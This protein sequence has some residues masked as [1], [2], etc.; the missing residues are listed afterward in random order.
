MTKTNKAAREHMAF[1]PVDATFGTL[2]LAGLCEYLERF[3][4]VFPD[5]RLY[6]RFAQAAYS[7]QVVH[8]FRGCRPPVGAKRR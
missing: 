6:C 5:S 8:L 7:G 4:A 1:G 2:F 3:R